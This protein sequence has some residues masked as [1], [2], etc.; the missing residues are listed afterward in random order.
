M[1]VFDALV[2]DTDELDGLFNKTP[3]EQVEQ[4]IYD[5]DDRNILVRYCKGKLLS[6]PF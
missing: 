2:I 3:F 1:S 5:G 4:F 6:K